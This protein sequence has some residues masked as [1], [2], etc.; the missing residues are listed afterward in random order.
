MKLNLKVSKVFNNIRI[1][2]SILI[3]L[4]S[5]LMLVLPR[6]TG[7]LTIIGVIVFGVYLFAKNQNF[8]EKSKLTKALTIIGLSFAII[9]ALGLTTLSPESLEQT[10]SAA[11]KTQIQK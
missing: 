5:F 1:K 2:I 7:Y 9:F 6:T 10:R 11:E 4:Y 3:V 8:K